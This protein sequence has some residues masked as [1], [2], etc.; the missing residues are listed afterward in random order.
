MSDHKLLIL[1]AFAVLATGA[2]DP[3][4]AQTAKGAQ[5]APPASAESQ[6]EADLESAFEDSDDEPPPPK[7]EAQPAAPSTTHVWVAGFWGRRNHAWVWIPGRWI[8]GRPTVAVVTWSGVGP[9]RCS[10]S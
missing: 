5:P 7:Q 6:V 4:R 10:R 1:V 8:A 2:N 3:V 9:P